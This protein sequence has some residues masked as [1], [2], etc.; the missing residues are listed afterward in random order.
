MKSMRLL[1][2]KTMN[3]LLVQPDWPII[4][5]ITDPVKY[6]PF[7]LL[8]LATM[9]RNQGNTVAVKVGNIK[10]KESIPFEPDE[11]WITTVFSW[12]FVYVQGTVDYYKFF[13]PD[14]TFRFGGVHATLSPE[15]YRKAFPFGKVHV[16]PVPEADNSELAWDL[17]PVPVKTQIVRF[18]SGCT[19]KCPW[20]YCWRFEKYKHFDFDTV[21]KTIRKNRLIINDNNFLVHPDIRAILKRMVN[22]RVNN[23]LISSYEVQG[24][25]DVRILA[26][27]LDLVPMLLDSRIANIRLA[28]DKSMSMAPLIEKCVN[29]FLKRG[30]NLKRLRTY[31]LYNHDIGFDE[32]CKK[33]KFLSSIRLGVIHSRFR[34]ITVL[35][36]G[37]V[38]QKKSQTPEEYYIH[39]G[40]TDKKIRAVGS[41]ASD[42]SR[43]SRMSKTI[44]KTVDEVR[45]Y[46]GRPSMKET[47]KQAGEVT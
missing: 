5:K 6:Y 33:L 38:K 34:P 11:I 10:S 46:Y 39:P 31:M 43:M 37:Y 28:F 36:D 20:C 3:I 47:I 21:A 14:C 4:G 29:E 2:G 1:R 19:N 18:S 42:I 8:K 22:F 9:L 32:T 13:Y 7:P 30:Y 16:G 23:R 24:G 40:W 26:K 35:R 41:I 17:M 15:V 12:F 27:N 25:F 45:S 44:V